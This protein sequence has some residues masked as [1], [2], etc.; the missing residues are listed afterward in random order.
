VRREGFEPITTSGLD[1]VPPADWAT[2]AMVVPRGV[3]PS[4]FRLRCGR[5]LPLYYGTWLRSYGIE[6][7]R[8]ALKTPPAHQSRP[9]QMAGAGGFEPP[10]DGSE[11][12]ILA[13]ERSANNKNRGA[14]GFTQLSSVLAKWRYLTRYVETLP[15]MRDHCS[16]THSTTMMVLMA[17]V[18]TGDRPL[19]RRLLC[20]LS[21]ISKYGANA[22]ESNRD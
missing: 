3:E 22:R 12:S 10:S 16:I 7:S 11:P 17:T 2:A 13:A 19:T 18:R 21:Y 8:A 5:S 1:R 6:P 15:G 14:G 20:Q 9:Q 4:V